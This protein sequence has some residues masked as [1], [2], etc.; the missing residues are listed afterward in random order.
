[1]LSEL[2]ASPGSAGGP[3]EEAAP[4]A[5][6]DEE[7][8][9]VSNQCCIVPVGVHGS[10]APDRATVEG[11]HG[12]GGNNGQ[13]GRLTSQAAAE[14]TMK[15]SSPPTTNRKRDPLESAA[16]ALA[17]ETDGVLYLRTYPGWILWLCASLCIVT[18]V[19]C[20]IVFKWQNKVIV[21]PCDN[22]DY[23]P[24]EGAL[25]QTQQMFIGETL[26]MILYYLDSYLSKRKANAPVFDFA[27][28]LDYY[29]LP[30]G[31]FWYW[32]VCSLFDFAA[33]LMIMISLKMTYASTIQMLRNFMVV[34]CAFL[35]PFMMKKAVKIHEAFGVVLITV[36][37]VLTAIPAIQTP[38]SDGDN[39]S[40]TSQVIIGVVL[41][42]AGTSLQAVQLILEEA[43]I[44]KGRSSP[45]RCVAWEGIG[46]LVYSFVAWPICQKLN[47]E[48]VTGSWY[49]SLHSTTISVLTI[50]Y[51]PTAT[52]FNV[53][54]LATTLLGSGL[55]RGVCFA[56]RS[57][58]VWII[59]LIVKWQDYDNYS[60]AS[61]IVFCIGFAIY[62]NLT[63]LSH[64]NSLDKF[65]S[66]P[67]HCCNC[68]TNPALDDPYESKETQQDNVNHSV[69][70]AA[71][72]HTDHGESHP[73]V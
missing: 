6:L 55:L 66:K 35:Q 34:I 37:M 52:A 2:V 40:S 46:G 59:S 51:V 20:S 25:Y 38:D 53:T 33:T 29:K 44:K 39:T 12:A 27:K 31:P 56:V 19:F 41:A 23:V 21:K 32:P 68:I 22:C 7:S 15:A 64:G 17:A 14:S 3:A 10:A 8:V 69:V 70:G 5:Y 72:P 42:V 26:A 49:A 13:N 67:I 36:A 50:I 16:A 60:L 58:L 71:S 47:M 65:L 28:S 4:V 63:G 11:T 30:Q 9:F 48:D 24:F 73:K 18:G 1:M 61:A 54:G 62:V 43:F 57:P 45:L